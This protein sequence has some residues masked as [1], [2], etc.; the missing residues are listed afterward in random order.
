MATFWERAANSVNDKFSLLCPFVVLVVSY[1]GFKGGNLVLI[2]PVPGHRFP[3]HSGD[4]RVSRFPT[5]KLDD[6]LHLSHLSDK[7]SKLATRRQ[8]FCWLYP[9]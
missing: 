4:L 1:L 8:V 7:S 9:A 3:F 6:M 5:L 2:A